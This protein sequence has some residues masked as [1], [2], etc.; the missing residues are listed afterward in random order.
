MTSQII[1][2]KEAKNI[3]KNEF[4]VGS[5]LSAGT[6]NA[7]TSKNKEGRTFI[8][9]L[10]AGYQNSLKINLCPK[11]SLGCLA[12]CLETA[13]R[14]RM[15]PVKNSRL[16]KSEYYVQ[17]RL[18]FLVHLA[19][20]I[21][22]KIVH[23]KNKDVT[24]YFRLNGTSDVD[25]L[26]QIKRHLGID[27]LSFD[28]VIFYDYTAILGKARKYDL[29]ENYFHA[30]SRKE[31]NETDCLKALEEGHPVA[32]VFLEDLPAYYKGFPVVSGDISD[33]EMIN[34]AGQKVWLGLSA[35]GKA[36]EDVSG[37]VIREY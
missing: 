37:F 1:T 31:D 34:Y 25:F 24:L 8:M 13:G 27:F 22:S 15:K 3:A 10:A 29:N 32:A 20:E 35:K 23:Y 4:N 14:G 2:T 7:K 26:G 12:A 21:M 30:F 11:A 33:I 9:Y 36:K 19:A 16:R 17:N 28:N 5:L 6:T 18:S